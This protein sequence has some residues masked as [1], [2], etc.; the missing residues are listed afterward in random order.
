MF[1]FDDVVM[2]SWHSAETNFKHNLFSLIFSDSEYFLADQTPFLKMTFNSW[3]T[4]AFV[5]L[6]IW[7]Q[8]FGV[9]AILIL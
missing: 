7:L 3:Y 6:T 4:T 9:N 5:E 1:P 2:M 8:I